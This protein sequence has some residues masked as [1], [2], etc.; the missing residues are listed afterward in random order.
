M[1]NSKCGPAAFLRIHREA[2]RVLEARKTKRTEMWVDANYPQGHRWARLLGF[3]NETEQ[4]HMQS[5]MPDGRDYDLY[6]RII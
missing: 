3:K 6:A 2:V 1:A 4:T 5:F